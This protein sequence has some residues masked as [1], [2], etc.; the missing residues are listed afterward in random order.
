MNKKGIE[1][2]NELREKIKKYNYFYYEKNQSLL[3]DYEYD[4]LLKKLEKEEENY[5]ELS[6]ENSPTKTV[7][8]KIKENKFKKVTHKKPMLSLSN[9]YNLNDIKAFDNRALKL[10]QKEQLDY[11]LELKLDGVSISIHYEKGK[12]VQA[13]TRGDGKIGEDVTE[14]ILQIESI[15]KYLVEEIDLEVRGEIILPLEIFDELNKKRVEEGLEV[16]AN[17]RNA[18]SGTLRQLDSKVVKERKLDCYVYYL[19]DAENYEIKTHQKSLEYLE[20][21]GF[22]VNENYIL[23]NSLKKLADAIKKWEIERLELPYETDGLVIKVNQFSLYEE[24][25]YTTKSP[26]WAIAYKF[27]A[28][29]ITTKLL[30]VTYQVGRTGA[31]T[32]VAE[33]E[34]VNLSG[35]LISRASLHNFDEIARKDIRIGDTVFIEKAAEIIPQVIK[36]VVEDRTGEEK[37]I[38]EPKKCPICGEKLQKTEGEVVLK[39]VNEN[40]RG[41]LERKLEYFVSRDAMNIDGLG[42]KI[43]NKLIEIGKIKEIYDIYSLKDYKDELMKLDKMGQKSIDKLMKSI[44]NSQKRE[45]SKVLYALGISFV[46]KYLAEILAKET[47]NIDRLIKITKEELIEINGV[48]EKVAT[49]VVNFFK[50]KK[51]LIIIEKLKENNLNF[52]YE[53]K[54]IIENIFNNK[55]F[56]I[57]GKLQNYK[58]ADMKK[59]IE[60]KGGKVLSGISKKLDCL[61]VGEKPGSKLEKAKDLGIEIMTEQTFLEK[62]G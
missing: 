50:Q 45:Y 5:P 2:I 48:G 11:I 41:K 51:N 58:R 54:K 38:E 20:K 18:A 55:T 4:M 21:L 28:K 13:V 1:N 24:L 33:L 49:S 61:I 30:D 25:G 43:L 22:K 16:F 7:G 12:L 17:P 15:P 19:V 10:S 53:E 36:V 46:G 57:T 34:P 31:V 56:L 6:D 40:C 26:R 37:R 29:Q 52:Q 8:S 27:P 59:L 23:C 14:N 9:T 44:E 60:K 3:S 32:P 42:P 35:S 39:C 47:K 62:M